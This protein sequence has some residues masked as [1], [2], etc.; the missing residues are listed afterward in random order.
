MRQTDDGNSRCLAPNFERIAGWTDARLD[1]ARVQDR[2]APSRCRIH[3]DRAVIRIIVARAKEHA[4]TGDASE[5]RRRCAGHQTAHDRSKFSSRHDSLVRRD[6]GIAARL[7]I[8]WNTRTLPV[9]RRLLTE[10][11]VNRNGPKGKPVLPSPLGASRRNE[12]AASVL[13]C[14]QRPARAEAPTRVLGPGLT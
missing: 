6:R 10:H 2:N 4:R 14:R 13:T 9:N 12:I 11:R 8:E 5:R 7:W 3:P 1:D